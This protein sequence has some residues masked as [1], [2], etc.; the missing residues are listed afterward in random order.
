MPASSLIMKALSDYQR[1]RSIRFVGNVMEDWI[2]VRVELEKAKLKTLQE[3]AAEVR[4]LRL[5][6]RGAD[7]RT[8]MGQIWR[9]FGDYRGALEAV[10]GA[11][12]RDHFVSAK[13]PETGVIIMNMHKSKG[14]QFDEVIIFEGWPSSHKGVLIE[15]S[16][17]NR[18]VRRNDPHSDLS[19]A[20]L[21]LRVGIT[22]AKQRVTFLTPEIDPCVLLRTSG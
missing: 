6:M 18:I 20:R 16:N 9:E 7:L 8:A 17:Q 3:I 2:A 15:G 10:R 19:A 1:I 11:F 4:N 5:L 13:T 14:K 21:T 12:V 22:R